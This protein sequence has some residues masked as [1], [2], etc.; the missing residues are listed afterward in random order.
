MIISNRNSFRYCGQV[1][2]TSLLIWD[3]LE[4]PQIMDQ[5]WLMLDISELDV[6][7]PGY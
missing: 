1:Y 3:N 6:W 2:M 5:M 7:S 4:I